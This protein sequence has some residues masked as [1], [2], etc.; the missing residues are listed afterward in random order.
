MEFFRYIRWVWTRW[1][2]WQRSYILAM[3]LIGAGA[4]SNESVRPWLLYP[5]V[6]IILAW[7]CKWWIWDTTK[8]SWKKYRDERDGLFNKIKGE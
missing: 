8:D 7:T 5:G 4:G 2:P 6:A 1:E 3:V